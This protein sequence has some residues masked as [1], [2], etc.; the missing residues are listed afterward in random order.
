MFR[1]VTSIRPKTR[2]LMQFVANGHTTGEIAYALSISQQSVKNRLREIYEGIGATLDLHPTRSP[3][4]MLAWWWFNIG[5]DVPV[6][7]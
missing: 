2:Q 6:K 1:T 7:A 3:R 4:V 5:K